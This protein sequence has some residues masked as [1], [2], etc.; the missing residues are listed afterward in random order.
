MITASLLQIQIQ[1][2][3][4][5]LTHELPN[6][7]NQKTEDEQYKFVEDHAW[8]PFEHLDGEMLL[9]HIE[10]SIDSLKYFLKELGVEI[11]S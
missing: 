8:Q 5:Y 6:D 4:E 11:E 1:A 3:G 2:S 7:W 9:V 10:N